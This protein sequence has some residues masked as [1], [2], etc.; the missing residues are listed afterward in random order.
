[1]GYALR[2]GSALFGAQPQ[3]FMNA[4]AGQSPASHQ[5][6]KP[7]RQSFSQG[8]AAVVQLRERCNRSA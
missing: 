3:K 6:A 5:A 7:R 1:M 4:T 2:A 8:N